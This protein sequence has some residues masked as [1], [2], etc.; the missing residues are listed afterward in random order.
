MP[1]IAH[2]KALLSPELKAKAIQL[3]H[4]RYRTF[5]DNEVFQLSAEQVGDNIILTLVL[6]KRDRSSQYSMSATMDPQRYAALSKAQ[7]LEI[8]LD[9]LDWCLESYFH[10]DRDAFLPLD[11]AS[12]RFEDVEVYAKGELRNSFLDDA[13][14]AWLRGERPDTESEWKALKKGKR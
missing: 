12:H 11:W 5:L 2:P 7:T 8:L 10:E 13:A 9:F 4:E 6:E 3:L 1:Q 14:D